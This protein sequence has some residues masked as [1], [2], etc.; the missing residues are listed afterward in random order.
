MRRDVVLQPDGKMSQFNYGLMLGQSSCSAIN[1][2][3]NLRE[4]ALGI[5]LLDTSIL[6]NKFSS[7]VSVNGQQ[8]GYCHC[9]FKMFM[10]LKI[11]II[12]K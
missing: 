9:Y 2:S 3:R 12:I 10:S 5:H 7:T 1:S 4:A 6:R 8:V 11:S